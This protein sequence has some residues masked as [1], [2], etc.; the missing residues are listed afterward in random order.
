MIDTSPKT[1]PDH[2]RMFAHYN[3]EANR[4]LYAACAEL[5][6]EERKL[7]RQAFFTS[8]HG[9]LNH[10]MVGDRLW[11]ARF[12]GIDAPQ[13]QLDQVLY[14]DF[15]ELS[16]ARIAEDVR[17]RAFTET[18][19]EDALDRSVDYVNFMGVRVVDPLPLA[20]AH[21]F[22]HQTHHRGQVHD[23]LGHTAVAPPP[24]DLHRVV[25]PL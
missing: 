11:M 12:E 5:S 19:D 15:E 14:E 13:L 2:Y 8:I 7:D 16:E 20:L 6:D 1:L 10:I 4:I 18:L 22:N 9:T 21:F 17:I 23:M 3:S 24:L 25:S